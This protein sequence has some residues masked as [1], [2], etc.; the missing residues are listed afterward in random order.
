MS[1]DITGIGGL[2]FILLM[3]GA[4]SKAGSMPFHS[5]IPDAAVDAPTPFMAFVPAAMEKLLGI[6]FLTR[7]CMDMFALEA[8]SPASMTLMIIGAATIILAVMMA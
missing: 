7:V 6:Y 2:A 8:G 4:I 1:L 5:W 3:I